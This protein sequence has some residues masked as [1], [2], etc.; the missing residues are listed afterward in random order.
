[1]SEGEFSQHLC[2]GAVNTP[3]DSFRH[4]PQRYRVSVSFMTIWALVMQ[5]SDISL[6]DVLDVSG[7][8]HGFVVPALGF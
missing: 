5:V 3:C 7:S 2:P 1:M 4:T 6:S 8:F